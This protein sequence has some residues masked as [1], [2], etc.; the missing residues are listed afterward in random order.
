[1]INLRLS[2]IFSRP[3]T[4]GF[5][6]GR[7]IILLSLS[8]SSK[9]ILANPI[10]VTKP[11]VQLIGESIQ[12]FNDKEMVFSYQDALANLTEF[13]S[14]DKP[15]FN[16]PAQPGKIWIY[17]SLRNKSGVDIWMDI[18]N[19]NLT[20]I[21]LY[22]FDNQFNMIDSV[23]MGALAPVDRKTSLGYSFQHMLL[24]RSEE[25]LNHFLIGI[26]TNLNFE[27]PI[28]LGSAES[29]MH[30]RKNY[31]YV[32]VFAIGALLL[33]FLYNVFIYFVTKDRIYIYYCSYLI[34]AIVTESYLNNFPFI[35]SF[36]GKN[37]AY[38]YLDTWL[39]TVF[40]TTGI[41]T[42]RYFDL[43]KTDPFFYKIIIVF[44]IVFIG[45][46]LMNLFVP[47]YYLANIFQVVAILFYLTCLVLSYRL[48]F[49]GVKRAQLY[50]AGWTFMM[51][52]AIIYLMVYN[53]WIPY[54][55]ITRNIAYFGSLIEILIFSIALGRRIS[56]LQFKQVSLNQSLQEKND[57]LV[58]LNESL[59]S[60]N[61]HV[62]HDLK[63]VLNNVTA[64]SVMAKKYN[65]KADS[66]KV[67]EILM[68][69]NGV[70]KNG[71]ETVQSFLSLGQIDSLLKDKNVG[72]IVLKSALYEIIESHDL[73]NKITVE[74]E[75]SNLV[76]IQ[77][78]PKAFES[79]FLNFFT[80]SIKYSNAHPKAWISFI[81]TPEYNIFNY[82]DDGIG[83]DMN[84]YG[85][86][87]FKVFHRGA[88]NKKKEGTGVGLYLVKRIVN[89]YGGTITATSELGQGL[90]FQL[91]FPK[92]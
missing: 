71:S 1:M 92:K 19:T 91:K 41:F 15:V 68:K 45:F 52:G 4:I 72:T 26:Q 44:I 88:G 3:K 56:D 75:Q 57:E 33:M 30:N 83:I 82:R 32:S 31:D 37:W 85:E 12:Y 23:Q 60:F 18:N 58:S 73:H 36:I 74:L 35:E 21:D 81:E 43:R 48:L 78:H 14:W 87:L 86:T 25:D 47:L 51:I 89:N 20:F 59:D 65:D 77:M 49:W 29:I 61:Y 16:G 76:S 79:I 13:S 27:I 22:K 50:C 40:F 62:S 17:F 9:I 69:L 55:A 67:D 39:W 64:L 7:L 10:T 2:Q 66:A 54:N 53:G 11:D 42:I 34:V 90:A 6:L 5:S 70:A 80:N 63:T 38:N 8:L 84:K 28:F 46:G 24:D